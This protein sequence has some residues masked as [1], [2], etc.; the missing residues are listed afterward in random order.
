MN[1]LRLEDIRQTS[2]Y[3]NFMSYLGWQTE[4]MNSPRPVFIYIRKLGLL[5]LYILKVLRYQ[6]PLGKQ[7]KTMIKRYHPIIIKNEP[8]AVEKLTGN[9]V[10]FK[11]N[12]DNKS[13]VLPTK[14]LWLNLNLSPAK[15]FNNL[16][17]K[18]RYNLKKAQLKVATL[19]ISGSKIDKK[20]IK[21]F[22]FLWARNKPFNWLFKPSFTELES[23]IECF[24]DKCFLVSA[25][26]MSAA[27][28]ILTSKNMASYWHNASTAESRKFFAPTLCIWQAILEAKRRNLKIFDFEGVWDERFPKLNQGWQ[29]FTRFKQGFVGS[30]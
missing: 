9:Q 25:Q 26:D 22:Y 17:P 12:L 15:L 16:K 10:Y 27:C 2:A 6:L 23:L 18:T 19:I 28:L 5:P 3:A 7:Y 13:P 21:D 14:T 20:I 1:F 24:R 11:I 30:S 29:G 8:F 4:K